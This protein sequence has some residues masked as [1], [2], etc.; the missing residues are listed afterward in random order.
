MVVYRKLLNSKRNRY[1]I[2]KL[3]AQA[4]TLSKSKGLYNDTDKD[5]ISENK[6]QTSRLTNDYQSEIKTT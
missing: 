6:S 5:V 4:N 3:T 1:R 2:A